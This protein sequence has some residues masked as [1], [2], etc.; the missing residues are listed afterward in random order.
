MLVFVDVDVDVDVGV[1]WNVEDFYIGIL[2]CES[3]GVI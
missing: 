2:C 3:S 1:W